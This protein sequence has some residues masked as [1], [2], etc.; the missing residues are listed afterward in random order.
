MQFDKEKKY[1]I[2]I[3]HNN[4]LLFFSATEVEIIGVLIVFRD[5]FNRQLIFPIES[6]HQS[7]E[8]LEW[9]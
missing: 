5:K 3:F 2:E 9:K 7:T 1:K 8:V 4:Q 6:L